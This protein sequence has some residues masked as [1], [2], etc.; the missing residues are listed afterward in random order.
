MNF[1]KPA[2]AQY[3]HILGKKFKH[4]KIIYSSRE[5]NVWELKGRHA[6]HLL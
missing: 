6:E 2:G 3:G 1:N 4:F 5:Q